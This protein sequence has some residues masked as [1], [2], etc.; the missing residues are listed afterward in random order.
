MF[1]N[2][3]SSIFINVGGNTYKLQVVSVVCSC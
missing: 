1:I 2:R 3:L